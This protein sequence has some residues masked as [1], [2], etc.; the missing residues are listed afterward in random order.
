MSYYE[1]WEKRER[2]SFARNREVIF[3]A[4]EAR[5]ITSV[6][7]LYEGSGDSGGIEDLS[8]MPTNASLEGDVTVLRNSWEK[9]ELV[10]EAVPLRELLE[11]TA[12]QIVSF[13]H[14]GWENN[15]GG[16]GEV[17]WDVAEKTVTL[18]HYD[19]FVERDYSSHTY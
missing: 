16:G 2:E 6:T 18:E 3:A 17:T 4:L 1:A 12:M 14:G 8:P 9:A 10:S 7:V 5:G 15:E 19:Y 11:D 13:D